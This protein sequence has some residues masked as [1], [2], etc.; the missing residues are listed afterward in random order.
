MNL[1]EVSLTPPPG[2]PGARR[3]PVITIAAAVHV[4]YWCGIEAAAGLRPCRVPEGPRWECTDA[5]A[6]RRR[7]AEAAPGVAPPASVPPPADAAA[8]GAGD[9][10]GGGGDVAGDARPDAGTDAGVTPAAVAELPG[11]ALAGADLAAWERA[12]LTLA[13][14]AGL[15]WRGAIKTITN[16]RGPWHAQP[17]SLAGH[18]AYRRSRAW[19]PPGRDGK[20]IG[21]AGNVYHL[22]LANFGEITGYAWAWLFGRPLRLTIAAVI[23]GG[24]VLGF[25]LG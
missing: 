12:W 8:D 4:C 14:W 15:W 5:E 1:P 20:I 3:A 22:T 25:W 19:I 13:H 18:D 2:C 7:P 11:A 16:P 21:P 6:C 9:A 10:R 17:E 23:A 24:I